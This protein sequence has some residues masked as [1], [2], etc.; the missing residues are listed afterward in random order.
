MKL[1]RS[2]ASVLSAPCLYGI[3]CVPL[4]GLLYGRFPD[5]LNEQGGT[6]HVPL[7][8]ATELIQLLILIICGY[9]VATLAPG[10][11]RHHVVLATVL[12]ML[13]GV[14]VQL[15][16]WEAVPVWH[17]FVFF[18]AIV[19]GMYLGAAIRARQIAPGRSLR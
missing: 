8:L 12:M 17:H 15:S 11:I 4:V 7:L 18:G 3:A 1:L 14:S 19:G 5:L 16:F 2:V 6:L 9:V 13:I 10:N